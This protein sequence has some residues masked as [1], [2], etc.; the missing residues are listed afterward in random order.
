MDQISKIIDAK[1]AEINKVIQ[2]DRAQQE[3][4]TDVREKQ[5]KLE[6]DIQKIK[7][8]IQESYDKKYEIREAYYKGKL[9]FDIEKAEIS[10]NEWMANQKQRIIEHE[11]YK[12]TKIEERKQ[13]L[14][15]RSNPY[16]REIETCDHL[17]ALCG[18]L[19]VQFGL[20]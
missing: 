2:D 14:A 5:D 11:E 9:E 10:Q 20:A 12:Q 17:I 13:A 6:V 15:D 18:K 1:Y 3:V 4:R 7:E 19:K 16:L 8:Q